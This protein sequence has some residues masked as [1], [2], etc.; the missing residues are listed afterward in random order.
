MEGDFKFHTLTDSHLR[1]WDDIPASADAA[2]F[3]GTNAVNFVGTQFLAKDHRNGDAATGEFSL[4][5]G[6]TAYDPNVSGR[7]PNAMKVVIPRLT[8]DRV[9]QGHAGSGVVFQ[10][11]SPRRAA[12]RR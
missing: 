9:H 7:A 3:L 11:G 2:S 4:E 5:L 8:P 6:L 12:S 1:G 10:G